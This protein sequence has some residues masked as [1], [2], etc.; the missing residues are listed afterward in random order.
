VEWYLELIEQGE[1]DDARSSPL[2]VAADG[3]ALA[4]RAGL[5]WPLRP[6]EKLLRRRL[7]AGR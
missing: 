4:G 7:L 6:A 2:S 3:I 1:F 5:L